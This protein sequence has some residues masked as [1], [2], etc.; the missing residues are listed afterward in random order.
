MKSKHNNFLS[1]ARCLLLGAL[2]PLTAMGAGDKKPNASAPDGIALVAPGLSEPVL[3]V[4]AV[5]PECVQLAAAD[6]AKDCREAT[7]RRIKVVKTRPAKAR[8][9][10]VA[11]V[12][13]QSPV[14]ADLEKRGYL[15]CASL[16]GKWE[17]F[18]IKSI[19]SP[20]PNVEQAL[21]VVGSDKRAAMY[22]LY[23]ISER[24]FG[25]DPMKFW[26]GH[27][28]DLR[29]R[30]DWNQGEL[31]EGP[32]T[33]DYRGLFINDEDL[34]IG[35]KGWANDRTI[36]PEVYA[37]IFETICRL[38]GN[39]IAPAMYANYMDSASRKLA[40]ARGLIYTASHL[41]ILLANPSGHRWE[42][43]CKE[44]YGRNL[45]YSF[46]Q[47]PE[48][49]RQFW[50]ES[51]Q[52]HKPYENLWPIGLRG[53]E[54]NDFV[55]Y[56]TTVP[57][58]AAGR[59]EYVTRVMGEELKLLQDQ[60][61]ADSKPVTTLTMRGDVDAQYR[62]GKLVV[63]EETL[64]VWG[65]EG[66]TARFGKTSLPTEKEA[67]RSGGNGVYYHLTYCDNQWVQWVPLKVVQEELAKAVAAKANRYV[68]FNVGDIR[69]LPLTIAGAM[70]V[71][72]KI[73][74]WLRD[75]DAAHAYNV[76]W[77]G[78]HFGDSSAAEIAALYEAYQALENTCRATSVVEGVGRL[79]FSPEGHR[80]ETALDI[81]GKNANPRSLS[82]FAA[83]IKIEG[84][85]PRFG[86][87]SRQWL[88]GC[89]P[90]WDAMYQRA[91]EL[92]KKIPQE[93]RQFY[94]DN[95]ILQ[96]QTS[97]QINHWANALLAG[98]DAC[99][100]N[101]IPGASQAFEQAAQAMDSIYWERA[102]ACHGQWENWFR[103]EYGVTLRSLWGL[104]PELHAADARKLSQWMSQGQP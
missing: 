67:A 71:A 3:L 37:A 49:M 54:D 68:L 24:A 58:T 76:R 34:L 32:P 65:D 46:N 84:L 16:R 56:D 13:G 15:D 38:K 1:G 92:E 40:D 63:P 66:S 99:A 35:W 55:Q 64:L 90:Q 11:G 74:P 77:A 73:D 7:N 69:E 27:K 93:R 94:F 25:T 89:A 57:K 43:F 83:S 18:C 80:T 19:R 70:D 9:L 79:T 14:L 39:L 48:A 30:V 5:A 78:Q 2:L 60:L 31:R 4:E 17:T 22:G 95:L 12:V 23:E 36:E 50:L 26:T 88:E 100:N 10:L 91:L 47:N 104:K 82:P 6:F 72:W 102:K 75:P 20:W 87:L 41:E 51:I 53:N 45:V 96:L 59:A 8:V 85:S 21:V 101:D 81:M 52:R 62:T 97:R 42:A 44:K 61:G 103:G 86:K 28:P 98:F 33:F 29:D